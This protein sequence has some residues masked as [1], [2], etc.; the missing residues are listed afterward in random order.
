[1]TARPRVNDLWL[2][3]IDSLVWARGSLDFSSYHSFLRAA[4][5]G[6]K[7][8]EALHSVAARI[9]EAGDRPKPSKLNQQLR[10]AYGFAASEQSTSQQQLPKAARI[11]L[12][13]LLRHSLG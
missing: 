5:L 3:F 2:S 12:R 1:M 13:Y 6:V 9:K 4:S 10:R 8:Q 11:W 7:P